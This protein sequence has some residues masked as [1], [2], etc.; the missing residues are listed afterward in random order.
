MAWSNIPKPSV[1]G[2]NQVNPQ[3]RENYDQA[4]IDYDS[5][6]T[7][8]D[9]INPNLWSEVNKPVSSAWTNIS[10]PI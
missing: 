2:W 1:S 10:K 5:A 4:D 8:Y 3:G 6:S 7:Y 9:G